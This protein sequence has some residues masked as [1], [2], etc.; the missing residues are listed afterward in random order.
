[1]RLFDG[2]MQDDR[3][4]ESAPTGGDAA[5]ETLEGVIDRV[6]FYS[7][8][9]GYTVA[10]VFTRKKAESLPVVGNM[11]DPHPGESV[12]FYGVWERHPK[13]GRQ[14]HFQSYQLS[15]P[16]TRAAIEVYLASDLV[17]GVGP[18]T[19][20]RL[21][22]YFGENTLDVLDTSPGRVLEVPKIGAK[23]AAALMEAWS[24]H[25]RI[26][27]IIIF[28]QSHGIGPRLAAKI[29]TLY[30]DQSIEVLEREPYRL[31]RDI[32][33]V[34]F[35][36][37]DK[38]AHSTGVK[39]DDPSRVEAGLRHTLQQASEDGHLYLPREGLL[40]KAEYILH[41]DR[42][43][44]DIAIDRLGAEKELC[45]EELGGEVGV[46]LPATIEAEEEIAT[47][48]LHRLDA[49]D[50]IAAGTRALRS[51]RHGGSIIASDE[52]A[53]AWLAR[54]ETLEGVELNH[55]QRQAVVAGLREPVSVITGGPGTGKT[56]VTRAVV[57]ACKALGQVVNLASPTGR[58]AK[59]LEQVA[60]HEARTIHR[61]LVFDPS[62]GGFKHHANNTLPADLVL[63]DE[64]SMV[65]QWLMRDLLRAL[66][67]G[68]R[69]VLVGDADQLPSVG[70]GNVLRDIVA[71][72]V[73]PVTRLTE[74]FRQ[75]ET[76]LIV[77]NAHR[78]NR[79]E[80]PILVPAKPWTGRDCVFIEEADV[81]AAAERV[82]RAATGNM[83]KLGFGP[84][85]VQ[86]LTPLRRGVLGVLNL[87]QRLQEKLN[88]AA[89]NKREF[90]RGETVFR[91][92]DRVLQ[93]VN[94]YDRMVYNGDIGRLVKVDPGNQVFT[95]QF[96][97]G[98]VDYDFAERDELDLAYALTVHKSQGSEYPAVVLVLHSSQYIMLQRN[99]FYTALTRAQK[100]VCI[101]GD[102]KAIYKAINTVTGS[103]R[104]TRLG[105]RLRG[106]GDSNHEDS[107]ARN[108]QGQIH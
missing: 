56:T 98:P 76:G 18:V 77:Q 89:P 47:H 1:M 86:V 99:L 30:G 69:L 3:A 60:R 32:S 29:H 40:A 13:Y 53:L 10:R 26:R 15:R 108:G 58:A 14:F 52:D 74:I 28:L 51:Q 96:E 7:P 94:N 68:A 62:T 34:G 35:L 55:L 65:D 42:E 107:K 66:D 83:R 61:M 100:M 102:K 24:R 103:E 64:V 19:A 104:Y 16:A 106:L 4:P 63:I 87:N 72:G 50:E 88:P 92:G 37:P 20:K 31:A 12:R 75:S 101:V 78:L 54:W 9:T 46:Y 11:L 2:D 45:I 91:E 44:I 71:S 22:D 85:D 43:L 81:E 73:L 33:G 67:P 5:E 59:R 82:I 25:Q 97:Q 6:T 90:A 36:T 105:L 80:P 95:V 93:T 57:A 23:R 21:V 17:P 84:D 49:R 48:L 38:I 8:D 39:D 79:G 41:V 27:N 70:P